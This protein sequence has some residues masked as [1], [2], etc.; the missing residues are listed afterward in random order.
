MLNNIKLLLGLSD[1]SKDELLTL[2]IEQAQDEA[3]NYIH[4]S[5]LSGLDSII[6]QMVIYRFN[7][8]GNEGL[9]SENYSG[10]SFSYTTEYPSF[11]TDG[12]KKHRKI[13]VIND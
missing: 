12:L 11:I 7:H 6:C 4:D 5:N 10:V 13:G 2:L 9:S 8:L 3:R 1:T